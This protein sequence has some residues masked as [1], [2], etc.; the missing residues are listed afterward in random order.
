MI[1]GNGRGRAASEFAHR[2]DREWPLMIGVASVPPFL[3]YQSAS[4][5]G[6]VGFLS[7]CIREGGG[8]SA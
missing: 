7:M 4:C 3:V 1:E 2:D 8:D 6:A 5:V